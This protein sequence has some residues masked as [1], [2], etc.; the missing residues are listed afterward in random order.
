MGK[1]K[2]HKGNEEE[3]QKAEE[4]KY[5]KYNR[6]EDRRKEGDMY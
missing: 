6:V 3:F 5:E 1:A 4:E 2:N